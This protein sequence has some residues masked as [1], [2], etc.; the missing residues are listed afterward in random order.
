M[1]RRVGGLGV[2]FLGFG[3]GGGVGGGGGLLWLK[4]KVYV[5]WNQESLFR[6]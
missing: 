2:G 5:C 6:F 4:E 3:F 1:A